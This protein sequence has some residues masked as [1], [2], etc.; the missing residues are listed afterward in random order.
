[1]AVVAAIARQSI[2]TSKS[3]QD[4]A[5]I[6]E[7][8]LGGLARSLDLL[9]ETDWEGVALEA[10]VRH[11]LMAFADEQR[12]STRAPGSAGAA[13]R[14]E[15]RHGDARTCHQRRE[16]RRTLEVTGACVHHMDH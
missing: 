15:Y 1:M 7:G 4:F 8:R 6:F 5:V 14:A 12:F 13:G 11:Q 9:V 16:I 2:R 3:P 10:L